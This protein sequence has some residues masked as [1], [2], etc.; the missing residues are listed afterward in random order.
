M[1]GFGGAC[2]GT[3]RV[4]G[5]EGGARFGRWPPWRACCKRRQLAWQSGCLNTL[6]ELSLELA[7]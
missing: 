6:L 7:R 4:R 2:T 5:A 1:K 3:P